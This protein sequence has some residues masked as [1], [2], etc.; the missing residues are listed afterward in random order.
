MTAALRT[1]VGSA[2]SRDYANAVANNAYSNSADAIR[3]RPNRT[4]GSE[5]GALLADFRITS[6]TFGSAPVAGVIQ[7]VAVDR[8]LSGNAGPTPSSTMRPRY[9]GA[10]SPRPQASNAATGWIMALNSV[11]LS[12]D[13]DYYLYNNGTGV[14]LSDCILTAQCWS[15]GV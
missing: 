1:N 2:I 14:S 12:P 7:L 11:A 15:P 4:D 8:D 3:I 6:A 5:Q 10:F 13:A 9:V